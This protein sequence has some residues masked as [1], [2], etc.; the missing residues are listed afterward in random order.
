MANEKHIKVHIGT[1]DDEISGESVWAIDLG[2][3]KAKVNNIPFF[4]GDV[5]SLHDVVRY[6]EIDGIK[7][8][9]EL[10][11]SVTRTWGIT[12]EPTDKNDSDG[13]TAEW[14]KIAAHLK[15]NDVKFESAYAGALCVALPADNTEEENIT[16]LKALKYSSPIPLTLYIDPDEDDDD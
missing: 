5:C 3:N 6:E 7:E 13:T 12:W 11:E 15:E 1:Y 10:L 2:D 14:Q 9:S 16:W 4:V 8:F